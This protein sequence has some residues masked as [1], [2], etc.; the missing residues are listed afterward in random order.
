MFSYGFFDTVIF[1][2]LAFLGIAVPVFTF[3]VSRMVHVI[4]KSKEKIEWEQSELERTVNREIGV[5]IIQLEEAKTKTL[6]KEGKKIERKI[7]KLKQ[8]KAAFQ[9]EVVS[10]QNSYEALSFRNSIVIPGIYFFSAILFGLGT[11]LFN[12]PNT[13]KISFSLSVFFAMLGI[14]RVLKCLKIM[15]DIKQN[16]EKYLRARMKDS[17][18]KS[19]IDSDEDK[20]E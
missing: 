8:K 7:E 2:W 14:F 18:T 1:V 3:G 12:I 13:I 17:F 10:I 11:T 4:E 5:L 9:R 16:A 19:L 6:A 15:F 20:D